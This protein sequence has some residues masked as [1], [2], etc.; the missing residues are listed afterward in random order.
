MTVSD[1]EILPVSYDIYRWDRL[2]RSGGGTLTAIKTTLSSSQVPTPSDFFN[3][4]MVVV[5]TLVA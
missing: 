5:A 1:Q 4:E 3:L 2:G